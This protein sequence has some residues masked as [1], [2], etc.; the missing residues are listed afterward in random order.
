MKLLK[1]IYKTSLKDLR[2]RLRS[3][4]ADITRA[5]S[6]IAKYLPLITEPSFNRSNNSDTDYDSLDFVDIEFFDEDLILEINAEL[7]KSVK[8]T[9]YKRSEMTYKERAFING[10]IRKT[11]PKNIVEIGVSAGGSSCVI[12][13]AIKDLDNSKLYSFDYSTNWYKKTT[14]NITRKSGFLVDILMPDQKEKCEIF[15]GGVPSKFFNSLPSDGIDLCFIDSFHWN[16]GEHLNILEILPHLKNDA[17]VI[18]HDTVFHTFGKDPYATTNGVAL[19]S[20]PGKRI[21]LKSEKTAGLANIGAVI[22]NKQNWLEHNLFTNLSLPWSHQ[23]ISKR[24][25]DSL[26]HYFRQYYSKDN[27]RIFL[28]YYLFYKYNIPRKTLDMLIK[29]V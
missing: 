8:N 20:L 19:N 6:I 9:T 7:E 17:V 29:K 3:N 21:I 24:D 4:K 14:D 13:N 28:F 15:T 1:A 11:K 26:F 25:F 23:E 10:I 12:L 2:N 27:Q 18:F 5:K 22:I 16:P